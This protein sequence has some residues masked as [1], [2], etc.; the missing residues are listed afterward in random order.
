ML[1]P[2]DSQT[3]LPSTP[4]SH[5]PTSRTNFDCMSA[6]SLACIS[7]DRVAAGTYRLYKSPSFPCLSIVH[8]VR[9]CRTRRLLTSS[10]TRRSLTRLPSASRECSTR[11]S[12]CRSRSSPHVT[13]PRWPGSGTSSMVASSTRNGA[14]H[15]VGIVCG[16]PC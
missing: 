15:A 7:A 3:L 6:Y 5:S 10:T 2:N 13:S 8:R 16:G 14:Y 4:C 9:S 11:S 12:G 1:I